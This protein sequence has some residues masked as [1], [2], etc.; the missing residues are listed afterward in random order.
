MHHWKGVC[1]MVA[2]AA[3]SLCASV[4]FAQGSSLFGYTPPA[5]GA[6]SSASRV[7]GGTRGPTDRRVALTAIA[8]EHVAHTARA[9]PVLYWF[10]AERVSDPIEVVIVD[11]R[12]EN[13]L[14]DISLEPPLEPG[15]HAV[16]L[17][18][19]GITLEPDRTYQWFVAQ[20]RDPDRRSLDVI[21]GGDIQRVAPAASVGAALAA[22]PSIETAQVYA[23]AGLWYELIET[24]SKLAARGDAGI[25]LQRAAILEQVGLLDAAA[26]DRRAAG[27]VE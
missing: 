3:L 21:S 1:A 9:Q 4:A 18:E 12:G 26:Y 15:V 23:E 22:G 14:L 11:E 17:V 5:R 6:P 2:G 27:S 16:S 8:P 7:G 19:Q 25:L 24:L 20:V 13:P 10:I